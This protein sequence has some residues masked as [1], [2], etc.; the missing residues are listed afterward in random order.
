MNTDTGAPWVAGT[1]ARVVGQTIPGVVDIDPPVVAPG[2]H[3][4]AD[5]KR[6]AVPWC[7]TAVE[8]Y[9]P[10]RLMVPLQVATELPGQARKP[11]AAAGV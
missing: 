5:Y 9:S 3:I 10:G 2:K 11:L 8:H 7:P 1:R 4:V 6:V